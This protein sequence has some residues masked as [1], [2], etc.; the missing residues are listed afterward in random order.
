MKIVEAAFQPVS[1]FHRFHNRIIGAASWFKQ[2]R[3]RILFRIGSPTRDI[4]FGA[5]N[6]DMNRRV[7]ECTVARHLSQ[8][9]SPQRAR[10]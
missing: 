7:T 4:P 1:N 9:V 3:L 10:Q 2:S 6:K 5:S 8:L